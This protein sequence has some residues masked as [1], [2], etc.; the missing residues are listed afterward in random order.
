[1]FPCAE[2]FHVGSWHIGDICRS[3]RGG[4]Q[5]RTEGV[6]DGRGRRRS[7]DKQKTMGGR[8]NERVASAQNVQDQQSPKESKNEHNP[9]A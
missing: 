6:G 7:N 4:H 1:M 8:K 5:S 9:A 2:L 3:S